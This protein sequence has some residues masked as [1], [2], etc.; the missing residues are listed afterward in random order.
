MTATLQTY[1]TKML[2]KIDWLKQLDHDASP[3]PTKIPDLEPFILTSLANRA[4]HIDLS[5]KVKEHAENIVTLWGVT[6]NKGR[7]AEDDKHAKML[8]ELST[9]FTQVDKEIFQQSQQAAKQNGRVR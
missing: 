7:R 9:A 8:E 3:T 6:C 2:E 5:S 1:Q 4:R